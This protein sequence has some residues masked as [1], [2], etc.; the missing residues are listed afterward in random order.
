MN[1]TICTM[2]K[3]EPNF[4]SAI[5]DDTSPAEFKVMLCLYTWYDDKQKCAT[6]AVDDVAMEC[7]LSKRYTEK[8]LKRLADKDLIR[9]RHNYASSGRQ[10]ENS[11]EL[12]Y[13]SYS[14]RESRLY[15]EEMEKYELC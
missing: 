1:R 5:F 13:R 14:Y 3:L 7:G 11:Y 12:I 2:P 4:P 10:C 15:L 9:I 8:L 6:L